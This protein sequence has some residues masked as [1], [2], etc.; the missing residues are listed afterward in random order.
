MNTDYDLD[1]YTVTRTMDEIRLANTL[2]KSID[3]K[4]TRTF[5]YTCGDRYA[6]TTSFYDLVKT[7]F[8]AARGV[9]SGYESIDNSDLYYM[10]AFMVSGQSG[11]ALIDLVKKAMETKTLI[12]FLFHGVGGEHSIDVALSEHQKL[13]Y[14][15]KTNE[16]EIWVAPLVDIATFMKQ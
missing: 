5:A 16:K 1:H 3:G 11:E 12:V 6:G 15:L 13:L 4:N 8:V 7:E 10:K 2:L 14:F 9:M